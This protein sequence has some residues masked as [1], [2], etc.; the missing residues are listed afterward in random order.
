MSEVPAELRP[1]IEQRTV[2]LTTYRRSGE[3]VG[4]PVNLVVDGD[5]AVFRTWDTAGKVKRLRNNPAVALAPS[6][7]RGEPTGPAIRA[8]VRMLTGDEARQAA[9]LL[10]GK[11]PVVHRLIPVAHRLMRVHT[12]HYELRPVS[13]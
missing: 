5:R 1:F 12:V 13:E 11:Y 3:G 2:L 9:R 4:T 7:L 10:S 6:T 8:Q